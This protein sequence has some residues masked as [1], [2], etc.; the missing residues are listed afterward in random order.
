MPTPSTHISGLSSSMSL[1]N[2]VA[3]NVDADGILRNLIFSHRYVTKAASYTVLYQ[4]TGTVFVT[5]GATAAVT[6]T[7][8]AIT[9]GSSAGWNFTF[10][11]GADQTM[12]VAT[13]TADTFVVYNDLT[14]DSI[15]FSTSSEKIGGVVDVWCN[16]TS[17]FGAVRTADPR[18]Q[19]AT[20]A[21]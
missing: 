21:T 19:T 2:G 6:F 13:A 1:W 16:G 3:P 18:Y 11:S 5:T 10:I 7:L 4:E 8:P 15:A 20:I 14:A 9:A 12:T 17:V